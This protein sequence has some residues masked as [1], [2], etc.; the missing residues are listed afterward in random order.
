MPCPMRM[1]PEP[2]TMT[3]FLSVLAALG[4]ELR[5]LRFPRRRWSRNTASSA[6]KLGRAGI[7]HLEGGLAASGRMSCARPDARWS[8]P[9][10]RASWRSD[11][12][13]SVSSPSASPRSISARFCSLSRNHRSILV[14]SWMYVEGHAALE[15]LVNA[16][17]RARIVAL[18]Q[19]LDR[20]PH[21][22]QL[23]ELGHASACPGPARWSA[24][25]SSCACSKL[26]PMAMTSPVAFI[27]V[28]RV[29]CR[30]RQTCR[31]ATWGI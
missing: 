16:E 19:L 28:P 30:R 4:N 3:F 15:G 8:C 18:V 17:Q 29:R 11:T 14:M 1:G 26:L 2:N 12:F 5:R 24:P 27:W 6:V 13:P 22:C 9:G 20:L 25:P 7:H 21:R 10:S 23:L 31:T